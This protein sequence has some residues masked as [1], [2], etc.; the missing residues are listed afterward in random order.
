LY[1]DHHLH[2][3]QLH[4]TTMWAT[5]LHL[6]RLFPKI[7]YPKLRAPLPLHHLQRGYMTPHHRPQRTTWELRTQ[8]CLLMP[9]RSIMF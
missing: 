8:P 6:Y 7:Q 4:Q 5:R 9:R 3:K 2:L 1:V